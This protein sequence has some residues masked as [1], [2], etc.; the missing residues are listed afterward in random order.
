MKSVWK[1]IVAI[2]MLASFAVALPGC[3]GSDD[4]TVKPKVPEGP[5]PASEEEPTMDDGP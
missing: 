5:P 2:V 3:G 1:C 4:G